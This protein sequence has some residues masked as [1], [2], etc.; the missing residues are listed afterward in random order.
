M[1]SSGHSRIPVRFQ[2]SSGH[3]DRRER[4]IPVGLWREAVLVECIAREDR[5]AIVGK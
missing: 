4:L 3:S 1:N 2:M 5:R